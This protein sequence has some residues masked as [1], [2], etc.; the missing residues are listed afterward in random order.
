MNDP[1]EQVR[2]SWIRQ[3]GQMAAQINAVNL[4]EYEGACAAWVANYG[5]PGKARPKPVSPNAVEAVLSFDPVWTAKFEDTG[6]PLST[7]DPASALPVYGTDVDAVGGPVGGPIP[8]RPGCYYQSSTDNLGLGQVWVSP[9]GR[10]FAKIANGLMG[11]LW[12]ELK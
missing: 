4:S 12:M 3:Q 7:L 5:L 9:T 10:E 1:I 8:G 6:R 2:Q 11:R